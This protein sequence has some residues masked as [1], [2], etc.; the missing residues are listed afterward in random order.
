MWILWERE[1]WNNTECLHCWEFAMLQNFSLVNGSEYRQQGPAGHFY[2]SEV[3][4]TTQVITVALS[5]AVVFVLSFAGNTFVFLVFYK[6]PSLITIS[7]RFIVNLSVCNILETLFV[8]PFV[9]SAIVSQ[10]WYFGPFWCQAT[11]FLMN[12]IFAAS[13]LTLLVIAVDR[14]CAVVT[15]LH[16]FMRI[17]PTRS[18]VMILSVWVLAIC[19]SIP[20]LLGWN[21]YEY[22]RRKSACTSVS[23][24]SLTNDRSYTTVL[25]AL[26]FILPLIVMLWTYCVIFK[27]ARNNSEKVRRNSTVPNITD[28][29]SQTPLRNGRRSSTAPILVHRLSVS[30]RSNSLLW[31]RDEWKAAVTSCMVLSTFIICWLLYFIIIILECILETSNFVTP[32]IQNI[33]IVLA[34]S[35]SAFNPLVYVFRGKLQRVELKVILGI[36]SKRNDI[37]QNF[38]KYMGN[39]RRPSA[40]ISIARGSPCISRQGSEEKEILQKLQHVTTATTLSSMVLTEEKD[41]KTAYD[42]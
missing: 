39:S 37:N 8:M 42:V 22:Q 18:V 41:D 7:N 6:R 31:R 9:F 15:P 28:D 20:P 27:A 30:S 12:A 25:V 16:Y 26:C 29:L 13:T 5:L 36:Q 35:S 14:Y 21:R 19:S 38:S 3:M 40:N 1:E 34:M 32:M 17:T 33:S 2:T 24:S 4:Q 23:A 10:D 11:G